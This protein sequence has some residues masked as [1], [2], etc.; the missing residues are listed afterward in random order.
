MSKI[1]FLKQQ[2]INIYNFLYDKKIDFRIYLKWKKDLKNQKKYGLPDI[3]TIDDTL[4]T[5]ICDRVSI[6]R[7]GDG[8]FK[9]M[10]GDSIL[11]QDGDS[12]LSERLKEVAK[13]DLDN[14]LVCLPS[15]FDRRRKK[16]SEVSFSKEEKKRKIR[17]KKYMDNIIADR[18]LQWYSYLNLNN[19]YGDSLVSRFYAGVYDDKKSDRWVKKWK[20]IWCDRNLLIVEGEKTRLGVGNDLFKNSKSIKRILA[21]ATDAYK[22]Y[23][24]VLQSTI[25]NYKKNDLVLIA[26]G[27]TA[28]VL[29]YDLAKCGIQA[30]DIGHIDIEYEWYLRKDRTHKKI[31]GKYVSEAMR[32]TEVSDIDKSN[33][34]WKQ[35]VDKIEVQ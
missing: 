6:C 13:S 28:T 30:L 31:E 15:F 17:A 11:F 4:D 20:E 3:M 35:I 8:E 26:L 18:R 29:A 27:P 9:I 5:I 14:I 32:G 10:D 23:D 16:I 7:Y 22:S 34:Y 21:P 24:Q 25:K 1:I 19:K 2:F 33:D 12:N